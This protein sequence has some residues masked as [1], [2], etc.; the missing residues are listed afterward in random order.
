[1]IR[2]ALEIDLPIVRE[3]ERAAGVLFNEAGMRFVGEME[4]TSLDDLRRVQRDGRAWVFVD[5]DDRP[6]AFMLAD[7]VD[8]RG[9]VDQVSVHP[10]H[11]GHGIGR[12]LIDRTDEW[13]A[14]QGLSDLTLTTYVEVPWNGPYYERLGFRFIPDD[15]LTDGL[16]AIRAK[17]TALGLDRWPRAAMI[18]PRA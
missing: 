7:A 4:P 12:Q 3:I 2:A 16:R 18:R 17:E 9:H 11:A 10:E 8:G 14:E 1:M 5:A 13:A 15:E 6:V